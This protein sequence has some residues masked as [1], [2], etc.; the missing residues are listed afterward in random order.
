MKPS[1]AFSAEL[2]ATFVILLAT[3]LGL[4]ISTTHASVGAVMGVGIA[5]LGW[6]EGLDWKV[7]AKV[8]LSWVLTL[9]VVGLTTAALYGF[10]LPMVVDKPVV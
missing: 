3:K 9:P 1:K 5:D 4:P 8:F 10:V 7:L 2:S 6:R